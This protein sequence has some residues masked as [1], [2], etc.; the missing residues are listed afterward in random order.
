MIKVYCGFISTGTRSDQQVAALR[1]IAKRYKDKIELVYPE[2]H[3]TRIFHDYARCMTVED[4][5][6]SECDI[7]WFLDSDVCPPDNILDLITEA[8]EEW[9]VAGAPYPVFMIP[10]GYDSQQ[11]VFTVYKNVGKGFQPAKIP[12]S[13]TGW[14]EGI[15]TGCIFVKR[16]VFQ[17]LQKPYFEFKYDPETRQMTEGED[18]GFCRKMYDLGFKFY[19]DYSMV[20]DHFKNVSLLSVNNYALQYANNSVSAY[21]RGLRSEIAKRKLGISPPKPQ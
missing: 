7:L 1:R 2:L 20:C 13:G 6:H 9:K 5:L 17:Y 10:T 16:E 21:D 3:M 14:V 19:T 12:Q 8:K 4:F 15:A 18:L 11:L